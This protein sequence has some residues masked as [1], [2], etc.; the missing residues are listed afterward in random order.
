MVKTYAI[1]Y[2]A[3]LEMGSIDDKAKLEGPYKPLL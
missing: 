1:K 2:Y 3:D